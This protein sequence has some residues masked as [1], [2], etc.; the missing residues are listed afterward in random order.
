M[1]TPAQ[2]DMFGRSFTGGKQADL[3]VRPVKP[4][5]DPPPIARQADRTGPNF[6][7]RPPTATT[8][9]PAGGSSNLEARSASVVCLECGEGIPTRAKVCPN[10]Y[11]RRSE[12]R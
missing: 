6:D 10:C 5:S 12:G 2:L 1:T 11:T 8:H 3:F 7:D 9:P 4:A